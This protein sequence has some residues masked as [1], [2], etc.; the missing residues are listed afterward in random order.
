[1]TAWHAGTLHLPGDVVAGTLLR[2]TADVP[3]LGPRA[4]VDRGELAAVLA[5]RHG[6]GAA[7]V[8]DE[9]HRR[10]LQETFGHKLPQPPIPADEVEVPEY[11][12]REDRGGRFV[13]ANGIERLSIAGRTD[14]TLLAYASELIVGRRFIILAG[15]DGALHASDDHGVV[16]WP[17]AAHLIIDRVIGRVVSRQRSDAPAGEHVRLKDT[18][19][20]FASVLWIDNP[21]PQRMR[22]IR[23]DAAREGSATVPGLQRPVLVARRALLRVVPPG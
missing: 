16:V 7:P 4:P 2:W 11:L 23:G 21:G 22:G 6:Q 9:E 10:R 19:D 8:R 14:L 18:F 3:D 1:M 13:G 15:L 12:T 17:H 20:N 5:S